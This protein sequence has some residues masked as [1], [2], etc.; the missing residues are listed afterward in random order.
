MAAPKWV[1]F[2][3]LFFTSLIWSKFSFQFFLCFPHWVSYFDSLTNCFSYLFCFSFS[4][5]LKEWSEVQRSRSSGAD[6][7]Q[8]IFLRPLS[9]S[10]LFTWTAEIV[11]PADTP[12]SNGKFKLKISVPSNYPHSPPKIHFLTKICHPNIHFKSGEICLDI[13]KNEWTPIWTL[14]NCLRAIQALLGNPDASS[15]LNCDAGNLIRNGDLMGF[16]S[17]ARMYTIEHAEM[18]Q[19]KKIELTENNG[20]TKRILEKKQGETN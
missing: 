6:I 13:L 8:G 17:I 5:L 10:E 14:E 9:D 18:I 19:T 7:S 11:G 15:P 20:L 4:R 3:S 16:Q 12:Y 2:S 1:R